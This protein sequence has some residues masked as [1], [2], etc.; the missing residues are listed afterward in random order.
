VKKEEVSR[1]AKYA[2][3]E[4]LERVAQERGWSVAHML[5]RLPNVGAKTIVEI[6]HWLQIPDP[7]GWEDRLRGIERR[8][9]RAKMRR[10]QAQA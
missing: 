1:R 6:L 5:A 9:R 4:A 7:D 3:K 8:E 2:L 10:R